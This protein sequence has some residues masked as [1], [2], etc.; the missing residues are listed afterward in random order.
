MVAITKHSNVNNLDGTGYICSS[1]E[2][3]QATTVPDGSTLTVVDESSH[4][5]TGYYI[6]FNGY[7]NQL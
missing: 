6:A 1:T 4:T 7:W 3:A 5:V 2:F